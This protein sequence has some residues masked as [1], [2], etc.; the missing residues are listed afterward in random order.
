MKKGLFKAGGKGGAGKSGARID[1]DSKEKET[2][3]ALT[4]C[5][6]GAQ[7][8][9]AKQTDCLGESEECR[10]YHH[11]DL[12]R[13][14]LGAA[15]DLLAERGVH[16]T[17]LRAI[18]RRAGV[19]NR[20]PY[21]HFPDKMSLLAEVAREG[22]T[23][24]GRRMSAHAHVTDPETRLSLLGQDYVAFAGDFPTDFAT[25][26]WPEL[27][28]DSNFP[29]REEVSSPAYNS[30]IEAIAEVAGP[31]ASEEAV[32][33][34]AVSGWAAV[35]GLATLRA[36]QVLAHMLDDGQGDQV[37]I[38]GVL[39]STHRMLVREAKRAGGRE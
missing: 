16:G 22:F 35:H 8:S 14:L 38:D 25:M 30:L 18:A 5:C 31:D 7:E 26:Y 3:K 21:H 4:P 20:A 11:G 6:M 23:E 17:S 33:M 32:E 27:C 10:G 19:S 28:D 12:R 34:V 24:L 36:Q 9:V 2:G 15:R 1:G 37:I 29:D 13:C 39:D